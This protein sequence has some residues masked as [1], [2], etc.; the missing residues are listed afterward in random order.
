[1]LATDNRD[2]VIK[3]SVL[4]VMWKVGMRISAHNSLLSPARI[5]IAK[6]LPGCSLAL[7]V[8]DCLM[9]ALVCRTVRGRGASGQASNNPRGRKPRSAAMRRA[10]LWRLKR[11][12]DQQSRGMSE[13]AWR[14]ADV[15][16]A[17]GCGNS[18]PLGHRERAMKRPE[19]ASTTVRLRLRSP[20]S[21]RSSW[22]RKMCGVMRGLA[23]VA[24]RGCR[25]CAG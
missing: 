21:R 16:R 5:E 22:V 7:A 2:C 4:A 11:L 25:H 9:S 8:K 1:M 19:T 20:K 15:G 13:G 12:L 14:E 24:V 17:R 23:V 10:G 6:V 3:T 18:G